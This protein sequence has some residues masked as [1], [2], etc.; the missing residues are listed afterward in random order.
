MNV[1][2]IA[3]GDELLIG[4]VIDTNSGDIARHMAPAGWKVNDV[5]VVADSPQ[6]IKSAIAR[7]FETSDVVLTTGGLGPTKDDITK[8]V[9]CEIFG[10]E[11]KES[12]EV[13]ANVMEVMEKRGLK[14][15][16]LTA[17]QAIV[18]T[19]CKVIQNRVGTAPI[20]WF[21]KGSKV[22][23][24][25]PG[26]PFETRE[27]FTSEVFPM[28]CR[29]FKTDVNISHRT[30]MVCDI[31][32][33]LLA[34]KLDEWENALPPYLHLAYLPKPGLIRLR[35]DGQHR[36]K[37][38]LEMEMDR[39]YAKLRELTGE[40]FLADGDLTPAEI[41]L[42][43]LAEHGLSLA[44]AESCTGGNIAHMITSVPGSSVA[45][46]GGVV[47]Y[48]NEVKHALL[49]VDND[50]LA[51][52]GAVSIPVVEQMSKGAC[53]ACRADI[54]IATSGIAGPGGGSAE[55]PVGTVC[56]AVSTPKFT[57]SHTYHFPGD[58]QRVIDRAST[59]GLIMAVKAVREL[60]AANDA[61][62]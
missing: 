11:M 21:E 7:A 16:D 60:Q 38:M 33:S 20:M 15:N 61:P 4:Q 24:A 19:S 48:S 36:D 23:V 13:L 25:M 56:I 57:I 5:Q 34:T 1:S 58:R 26:V 37:D 28:L 54:G 12:P 17:A 14:L 8:Q 6:A 9:M 55:K 51:R 52:F 45:M 10:G 43:A 32:E 44:T 39:Q 41:L 3:I 47:A 35:L 42:N 31:S 62:A 53:N 49:D 30:M 40:H 2:I 18:P 59:T 29:R 50:T 46:K 27:M 22:L